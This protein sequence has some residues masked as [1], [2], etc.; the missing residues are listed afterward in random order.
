MT[1]TEYFRIFLM[2]NY[3]NEIKMVPIY[4]FQATMKLGLTIV[5]KTLEYPRQYCEDF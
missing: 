4:L 2:Y 5:H 1:T 3:L